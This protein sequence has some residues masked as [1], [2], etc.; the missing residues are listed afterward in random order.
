MS[1]EGAE[2]SKYVW[3]YK[4]NTQEIHS[5][6]RWKVS[7]HTSGRFHRAGPQSSFMRQRKT[8]F[9]PG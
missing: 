9:A 4:V 6:S 3:Y 2:S 1:I 5:K 7:K 8:G